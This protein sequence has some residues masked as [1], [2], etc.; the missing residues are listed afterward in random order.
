V[1][2]AVGTWLW[3]HCAAEEDYPSLEEEEDEEEEEEPDS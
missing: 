3:D 1:A 2:A